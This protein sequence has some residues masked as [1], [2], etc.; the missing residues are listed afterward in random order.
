MKQATI[1]FLVGLLHAELG[2]CVRDETAIHNSMINGSNGFD[3]GTDQVTDQGIVIVAEEMRQVAASGET[4]DEFEASFN[5]Q[6]NLLYAELDIEHGEVSLLDTNGFNT[7]DF[8]PAT[9]LPMLA[10]QGSYAGKG[11]YGKVYLVKVECSEEHSTLAVKLEINRNPYSAKEIEVGKFFDHAHLVKFY[12]SGKVFGKPVI[13]MEATGGGD[14]DKRYKDKQNPLTDKEL[15][16]YVLETLYGLKHIHDSGYAHADFKPEQVML[17]CDSMQN[18]HAKLGDFGFTSTDGTHGIRGSPLYMS[19]ELIVEQKLSKTADMWAFGVSLF[20]MSHDGRMPSYLDNANSIP[21][22]KMKMSNIYH[23]HQYHS[24]HFATPKSPLIDQLISGLLQVNLQRRLTVDGAIDVATKWAGTYYNSLEM[25][26]FAKNDDS[27]RVAL[28]DC[29][30]KCKGKCTGRRCQANPQFQCIGEEPQTVNKIPTVN[31]KLNVNKYDKN[32]VK[33]G[34]T[35]GFQELSV[36]LYFNVL[37]DIRLDRDARL[38][39]VQGQAYVTGLRAL[40]IITEVNGV[41]IAS[42]QVSNAGDQVV[43]TLQSITRYPISLKVLRKVAPYILRTPTVQ[44]K[45]YQQKKVWDPYLNYPYGGY[46]NRYVLL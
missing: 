34:N 30:M 40:D 32:S 26:A 37:S 38:M 39:Q 46:R 31:N 20:E 24:Y 12:D 4:M 3:Q 8:C 9:W 21:A 15:S 44:Q 19:P 35:E 18:C 11:Q 16:K 13:L 29:W 25:A 1:C 43:A 42:D 28:P 41:S 36:T 22:L 5:E 7:K 14:L 23:T 33:G 45:Q 27:K 2:S 10:K 6:V 17:A